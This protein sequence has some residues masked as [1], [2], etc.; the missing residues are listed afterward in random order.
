MATINI[1]NYAGFCWGVV[2]T[3]DKV[4][5][6]LLHNSDRNVYVLGEIIHNPKEIE[7]LSGNGLQSIDYEQLAT[8][9][10]DDSI[11]VIRAHGE[12]P[13]T[14]N[15]IDDLHIPLIDATC[16]LVMRL[17]DKLRNYYQQ[18]WQIVI[19][20]KYDHAEVL[21]LRGVCNDECIVIRTAEDMINNIDYSRNTILCSQTTMNQ[22]TLLSIYEQVSDI[23]EERKSNDSILK[24]ENTV[25][26]FM[27][28]RERKLQQFA[29]HNDLV[30]FVASSH[31]SN[32]KVLYTICSDANPN[33]YF[34]ENIDEVDISL[35]KNATNIGITG[36]TSTPMWLLEEIATGV[37]NLLNN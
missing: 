8:I 20:G 6:T 34:I 27:I 16:P 32:G 7:R 9:S 15:A 4:E 22:D 10:P 31:S 3:I 37:N 12:P 1:D 11:V 26:K 2:Q 18:H 29:E 21:G 30:L 13:S 14:Y 25:C 24:L 35:L 36:A 28:N 19:L 23:F 33:T 5:D 17:Q